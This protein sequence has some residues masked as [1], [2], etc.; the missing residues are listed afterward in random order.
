MN[1]NRK[2]TGVIKGRTVQSTQHQSGQLTIGFD[3]GSKMTVKT[4]GDANY[5]VTGGTV[6]AVRQQDTDLALDFT[7]GTTMQVHLAEATSSVMLR[8]S[9]ASLE[10][11]D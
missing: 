1:S 7:D 8:D 2:L 10:Y 9:K 4:A 3:D 11:V 6:K 5:G